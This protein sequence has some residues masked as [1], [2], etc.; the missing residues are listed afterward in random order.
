MS[1]LEGNENSKKELEEA[2]RRYFFRIRFSKFILSTIKYCS[3]DQVRL[4]RKR[5][6]R[7]PLIFDH[8][9]SDDDKGIT[10]GELIYNNQ[11]QNI[12]QPIITDPLQF[13]ASLSNDRLARAFG[14]LTHRQQFI[15]TLYYAQCYRDNEIARILGVSP[16]AIYKSR[17]LALKKLQIDIY[18]ISE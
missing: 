18:R 13:K 3:L 1:A 16:Q 9:V 10:L 11:K 17:N 7:N 14:V 6:K 15:T 2:F 4:Y 12:K 8:P 5:D